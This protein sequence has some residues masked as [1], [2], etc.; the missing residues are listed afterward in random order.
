[1]REAFNIMYEVIVAERRAAQLDMAA[2]AKFAQHGE[3]VHET[4]SML[5]DLIAARDVAPE[6]QESA[7]HVADMY[8]SGLMEVG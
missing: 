5:D 8:A 3:T 4:R 7:T 2:R 1:M 6:I